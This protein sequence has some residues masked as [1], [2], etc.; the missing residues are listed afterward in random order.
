MKPTLK[1]WRVGE[2]NHSEGRQELVPGQMQS[3]GTREPEAG[4]SYTV[5]PMT[6][7]LYYTD[8]YLK[9]FSGRI[10]SEH[11]AGS[12]P[13][14]VLDQTA[15]YPESG[16]QPSDTG[17]LAEA[18]VLKVI[19]EESGEILHVL[20][21]PIP[22]GPLTGRIDWARRFDH[23]QQHTGQHI[24]SQAFLAVAQAPTVSFHLGQELSTIDI[25]IAQPS[26]A[27]M[28]Q[29]QTL[30]TR[31]VF[32]NHPVHILTADRESLSS[33]G[34]RKESRREGEIRVVEVEGFDRSPCG[35]THVRSTGEIGMIFI[36]GFE[37]YKG[38]TRVEFVAGGRALKAFH[39]EHELL[40]RLGRIH[41]ATLDS[42][43]ELTERLIQE[44]TDLS[45][46][47]V[48]LRDQLLDMEAAE[49]LQNAATGPYGVMVR[50][51]FSGRSLEGA[52]HLAQKLTARPGTVAILG[53]SDACQI[54]VARSREL[55]GSCHEAVKRATIELGGKGGGRPELAQAGGIPSE[56][57]EQWIQA[58]EDYFGTVANK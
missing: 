9:E 36:L 41:S 10:L 31:I 29:A 57:L 14:V 1:S 13:A 6:K 34:V 40:T 15:F 2:E 17:S 22:A 43:P 56:H 37:R 33:L 39:K 48:N 35:G 20:D 21:R 58:V 38:G 52:K 32:E 12:N 25:E 45:R 28:E 16:G 46:E 51:S 8:S 19:E 53:I 50:K 3:F 49:L 23:M 4:I 26:A 42:I 5:Q 55:S 7:H 24:L 44:K 47:I 27:Q 11:Q 54:V 18:R 30:A